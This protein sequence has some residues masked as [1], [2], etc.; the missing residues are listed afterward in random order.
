MMH[1]YFVKNYIQSINFKM[2][3]ANEDKFK[4][5]NNPI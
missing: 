5:I 4:L 2:K 3:R 1:V